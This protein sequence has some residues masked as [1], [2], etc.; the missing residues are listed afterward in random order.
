MDLDVLLLT[1]GLLAAVVAALSKKLRRLPLSEPLLALVAGG[2]LG[3]SATGV[4]SLPTLIRDPAVLHEAGRLLLAVSVMGVALRYPWRDVRRRLAAVSV[5]LLVAMPAMAVVSAALGGWILGLPVAAAALLGAAVAPTD[6]VLASSVVT[7]EEAERDIPAKDRELLSLESGANDGL[8]LPLV[9]AAVAIA[10]PLTARDAVVESLWQVLGAV[11]LGVLLGWLGGR[12]LLLGEEHGAAEHAPALL[13]TV[14]LALGVMGAS[15]LLKVDG[16]LAV[17]VAG[18]AFSLTSTG[19]ERT[20]ELQLDE[21]VNRFAVLPVFAL[22]GAMIPWAAWRDLGWRGAA[23]VVAVLMLRRLPVVLA[24]ARPLGLR[25]R[26]AVYLGWFGPVGVS[27][28]FYL[29]LEAERLSV[30]ENVLAAGS[31]LVVASTVAHGLSSSPGRALYRRAARRGV[32]GSPT[33]RVST[34]STTEMGIGD[35]SAGQR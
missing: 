24:L 32:D 19:A 10:G 5:L 26:D 27:A 20:A 22:L 28:V 23:L 25:L 7:G 8:A 9:L 17:F 35:A 16:V 29:T 14:V 33:R 18:L 13:F 2:A 4:L 12:M 11:A 30:P 6:P 34:G 3:A 31:L 21:A 1:V 15:G